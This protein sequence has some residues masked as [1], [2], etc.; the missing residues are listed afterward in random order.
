MTDQ[1]AP[2]CPRCRRRHLPSLPC[3][4]GHY[5]QRINAHVLATQGRRC[6]MCGGH[7]T[8]ADHV[9]PRS[10]GGTDED[11]NLRPACA[12]HNSA[13]GNKMNPFQP[14]QTTINPATLSARWRNTN[15]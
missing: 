5:A 12:K 3:W 14:D 15:G 11:R 2:R 10:R 13:R 4:S 8:S 7:A 9:H 6:W 1:L